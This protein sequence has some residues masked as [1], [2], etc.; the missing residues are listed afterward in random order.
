MTTARPFRFGVVAAQARS[1]QE[2]AVKALHLESMGYSTLLRPDGLRFTLA[3]LPALAAAP[4][5]AACASAGRGVG[6]AAPLTGRPGGGHRRHRSA[7]HGA[8]GGGLRADQLAPRGGRPEVRSARAEHHADGGG[9]A[10]A[11]LG[12]AP[13]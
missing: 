5:A 6:P 3:P 11:A 13:A 12:G 9:R 10:G 7:A 8:G 2:W 4:P 1:G